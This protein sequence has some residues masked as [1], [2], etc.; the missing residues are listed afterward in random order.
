[1]PHPL[2]GDE[3]KAHDDLFDVLMVRH[4]RDGVAYGENEIAPMVFK[5]SGFPFDDATYPRLTASL[6]RL[7][8]K[9]IQTYSD[10]QRAVMQRQLWALF[11][12]TTPS[13]FITRR[14]HEARRNAVRQ[15]LV[16]VI[17][18]LALKRSEI[19]SLPDT[20]RTTVKAKKYPTEFD[21]DEPTSPFLP[22]D[23]TEDSSAW[24]CFG[25]GSTPVNLHAI[26]GRWRSAFF[27]FIRLPEGRK[28]TIEY[29]DRW[30]KHEVF[31]VGTQVALIEKAFLVS[32]QGKIVLS[33]MTVN[34]QVRA[35]R[36]VE[37]GFR[38]TGSATQCVAEFISRPGDY[39]R[40]NALMAAI[41]PT[42]HRLKTLAS[43]GG[44]QDVLD[45]VD[46][47]KT[48]VQPRL[49]QCM[50]CHGGAGNQSLG[51][52]VAPRGTFKSFQR[53]SQREI[54]QATSAAKREDESWKLL[55]TAWDKANR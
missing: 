28:A 31:P 47:P 3:R 36:N 24:V 6:N 54:V 55:Q 22:S 44:K 18:Q 51:D 14:P 46:N 23:L 13:R 49:Q 52:V 39:M 11:D 50:Q 21:V 5:F 9:R 19:E 33:P 43:D 34:V 4:A 29:V 45:L 40:G 30:N 26:D 17:R 12:L 10:V 27:Q 8:P 32:D 38:D 48:S 7:T 1:L 41:N 25:R 2:R 53:R 42:D 20:L 35:Y 37:Q 15:Q 16:G